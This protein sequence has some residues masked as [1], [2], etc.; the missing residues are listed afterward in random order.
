M[1][2]SVPT[3]FTTTILATFAL[4]AP[5]DALLAPVQLYAQPAALQA[6]FCTIVPASKFA[7]QGITKEAQP[8]RFVPLA[9]QPA[10]QIQSANLA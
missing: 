4:N 3:A 6:T 2:I 7:Q 8:V 9:A 1:W 10:L 5:L